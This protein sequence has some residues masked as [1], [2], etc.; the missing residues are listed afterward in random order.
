VEVLVAISIFS[1]AIASI[2][3]VF[4]SISATK[5][6]LDLNSETYHQAR[7]VLDRIGREVR[8][9]YMN[10]SA[11]S[12]VLKGGFNENGLVFF[13]LS[14]TATVA[15]QLTGAG[16][17]SVRYELVEDDQ[18]E[19]ESYVLMRTETPLLGSMSLADVPAIRMASGIKSFT[20]RY[21]SEDNWRDEWDQKLQGFPDMLEIMMTGYDKNGEETPFLTAFKLP[22]NGSLQ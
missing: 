7:V 19:N 17:V 1:L 3:G 10:N 8:G 15:T 14:T 13:E 22:V 16:F 20:A 12:N 11:D 9:I 21:F 6:K 4:T 18:N 5:D 2:Y